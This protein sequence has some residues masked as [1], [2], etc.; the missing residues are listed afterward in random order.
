MFLFWNRKKREGNGKRIY[1]IKWGEHIDKQQME[2]IAC[3]LQNI[4]QK[5]A[6]REIVILCIGSDLS[7]GDSLGPLVGTILEEKQVP[8]HVYGTL[9]EPVHAQNITN[10]VNKIHKRFKDPFIFS[11]DASLGKNSEIGYISLEEGPLTP[12]KALKRNLPNVGDYHIKAIV[13]E[14]DPS[15]PTKFL[16]ETRL[17]MVMNLSKIIAEM[18]V[19]TAALKSP[20]K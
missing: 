5:T 9:K 20:C 11:I 10:I 18:I 6:S 19:Q 16:K 8:Y 13:N 2:I 15:S 7:I 14:I 12:G 1:G 3:E 4:F 17:Y